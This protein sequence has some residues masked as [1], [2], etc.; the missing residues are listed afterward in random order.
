[1]NRYISDIKSESDQIHD[2]I[3][4]LLITLEATEDYNVKL[5]IRK[6]IVDLLTNSIDDM[7][8]EDI[9]RLRIIISKD[10]SL[11]SVKDIDNRMPTSKLVRDDIEKKYQ[12][13][14]GFEEKI[15]LYNDNKSIANGCYSIYIAQMFLNDVRYKKIFDTTTVGTT[16]LIA[17]VKDLIKIDLSEMN[18]LDPEIDS[19]RV[20]LIKEIVNK[21]RVSQAFIDPIL[22]DLSN[23][24]TFSEKVD[25]YKNCDFWEKSYSLQVFNSIFKMC[26]RKDLEDKAVVE[27]FANTA[28]KMITYVELSEKDERYRDDLYY[29]V[30]KNP[31]VA[32]YAKLNDIEL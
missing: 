31:T 20:N 29:A 27:F 14:H 4:G 23:C 13:S 25:V 32:E 24:K 9:V 15:K 3:E 26:N 21:T 16:H 10:G 1:M 18:S 22:Y 5:A 11:G 19:I 12:E 2:Y 17:I 7:K 8:L 30:T 6:S 28:K